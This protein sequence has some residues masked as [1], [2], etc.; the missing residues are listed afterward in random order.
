MACFLT[1]LALFTYLVLVENLTVFYSFEKSVRDRFDNVEGQ[2]AAGGRLQ[3]SEV[4]T[5]EHLWDYLNTTVIDNL[6]WILEFIAELIYCF[7]DCIEC[8][9]LLLLTI[10]IHII[11]FQVLRLTGSECYV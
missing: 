2:Y 6:Y 11:L 1:F 8:N 5:I 9:S 10:L 4:E 7:R 3:L